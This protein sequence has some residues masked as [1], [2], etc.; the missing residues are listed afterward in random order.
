VQ[1]TTVGDAGDQHQ[2]ARGDPEPAVDGEGLMRVLDADHD[3][4]GAPKC[5]QDRGHRRRRGHARSQRSGLEKVV[6]DHEAE[7]DE[8]QRER[9]RQDE[10]EDVEAEVRFEQVTE[11]GRDQQGCG[12]A[13]EGAGERGPSLRSSFGPGISGR[14][15]TSLAVISWCPTAS[16]GATRSGFGAARTG[17]RNAPIQIAANAVASVSD[18]TSPCASRSPKMTIPP[19][20]VAT[21]TATPV[22]A[23]T[24]TASPV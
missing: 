17:V 24:D 16:G 21:F 19:T 14:R 10:I 20:M 13:R 9:E 18:P 3:E 8:H 1:A 7:A 6:S 15:S 2:H 4:H 23:V 22:S 11:L 5:E 12:D